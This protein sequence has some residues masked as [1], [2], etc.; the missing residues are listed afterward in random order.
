MP[1]RLICFRP[2]TG[3]FEVR[4]A[5]TGA[6]A[7]VLEARAAALELA[8]EPYGDE[9]RLSLEASVS[10]M[11]TG[12][13]SM[14][15]QGDD[16]ESIVTITLAVLREFPAWAINEACL[17]IAD[18]SAKRDDRFA[19]NDAEIS[20]AVR[21]IVWPY[22]RALLHAKNFA[23]ATVEVPSKA[24][25]RSP[26]RARLPGDGGHGARVAADLARRKA[27]REAAPAVAAESPANG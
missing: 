10:A 22:Q 26:E 4:R 25:T 17:A 13:R 7:A 20:N 3:P 6:E 12:F 2:T 21:D 15:Q 8:L 24:P 11:L 5:L 1:R 27:E 19:P 9:D 14:R 23:A 18:G 16:V